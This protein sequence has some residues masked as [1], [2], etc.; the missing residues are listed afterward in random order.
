MISKEQLSKLDATI[1]IMV[2][3]AVSYGIA[4]S[5][6]ISFYNYY[7]LPSMFIDI[8]LNTIVKPLLMSFTSLFI[9]GAIINYLYKYLSKILSML[10]GSLTWIV[11]GLIIIYSFVIAGKIGEY[12]ASMRSNYTVLKHDSKLYITVSS[13][14]DS[15]IIAP[16]NNNNQSISPKFTSIDISDLNNAETIQFP[17]GLKVQAPKNDSELR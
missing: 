13:Y 7:N 2:L 11:I 5:Y 8:N 4:Y 12:S 17:K 16:Y 1:Y 3:T 14:K 6:L 10:N 9:L 15:I